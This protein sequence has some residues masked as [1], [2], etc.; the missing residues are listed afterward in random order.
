MVGV[1]SWAS[2]VLCPDDG[3]AHLPMM[4]GP[5]M[6]VTRCQRSMPDAVPH[7]G[8]VPEDQWRCPGFVAL[9]CPLDLAP[10]TPA[11]H[12]LSDAP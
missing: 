6:L 4:Q 7:P 11:G 10:K 12:R 2:W 3:L 5:G 1:S 8:V 9:L